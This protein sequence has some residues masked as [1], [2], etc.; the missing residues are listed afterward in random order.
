MKSF[1][2]IICSSENIVESEG[3]KYVTSND[4]LG[5]EKKKEWGGNRGMKVNDP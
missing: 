3:T 4:G 2:S 1:Y 5:E